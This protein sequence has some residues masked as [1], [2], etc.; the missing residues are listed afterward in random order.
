LAK[1]MME[2]R[3]TD[4]LEFFICAGLHQCLTPGIWIGM[5]QS[6]MASTIGR[7]LTFNETADGY[8]RGDGCSAVVLKYGATTSEDAEAVWAGSMV[9]QNGRSATLTAPNGLAQEDV[10]WKAIREADMSPAESTVWS[11]HGTGT[12][13]GDPIEVGGVRKV[14]LQ[15]DRQAPLMVGTNKTNT[16][17]LEGGAAMTS[18]IAALYQIKAH[19]A[20]P[21]L[22]GN[23]L[24]AYL[25]LKDFEAFFNH[26]MGSTNLHQGHVNISSF[27]FGGTNAHAVMW[28]E[29]K[30]VVTDPKEFWRKQMSKM[31][32]PEIHAI[33]PDPAEWSSDLPEAPRPGDV[34][35]VT[36][37]KGESNAAIKWEKTEEGLGDDYDL[38]D[39]C[40]SIVG[41]FND[42][43]PEVLEDGDVPGLRSI[44]IEVPGNGP[45]E[46]RFV[47][48]VDDDMVLAPV[49]DKCSK[50]TAAIVGPAVGLTNKWVARGIAGSSLKISLFTSHRRYAVSWMP[51]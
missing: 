26:E 47:Q 48:T 15:A 17:H 16:G 43:K 41:S 8:L 7:C 12:N 51:C 3:R 45:V 20:N 6:H 29:N 46:F 1:I 18:I 42:W 44:T 13:L 31:S 28:G 49:S 36:V 25:E 9:G 30:L 11:C 37:Q 39:V 38:D 40:Y 10:I 19:Y 24:N 27:G 34:W 35:S 23:V 32:P 21:L 5:S 4:K 50:K 33:G 22:H 14:M 2:N